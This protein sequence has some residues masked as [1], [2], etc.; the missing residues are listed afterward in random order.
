MQQIFGEQFEAQ[1]SD[2][3]T[4]ITR[5]AIQLALKNESE[6]K[7][8]LNQKQAR[9]YL[10]G[11]KHDDFKELLVLGLKTIIVKRP[12]GSTCVRYDKQDL[13]EFMAYYKV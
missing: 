3:I 2:S 12:S 4:D 6:N 13:D 1:L 11:M 5:S 10:G 9:D 7:R 8:Y